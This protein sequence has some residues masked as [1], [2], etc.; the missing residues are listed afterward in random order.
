MIDELNDL[1]I[2]SDKNQNIEVKE[3]K[4]TLELAVEALAEDV[5]KAEVVELK[6]VDWAVSEELK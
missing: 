3:K 5:Q 6:C 4:K 1:E 2:P